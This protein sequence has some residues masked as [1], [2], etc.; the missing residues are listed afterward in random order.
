MNEKLEEID[1][2]KIEILDNSRIRI[3]EGDLRSLIED[4]KQRGLLQPIGVF[5]VGSKYVLRFG[6]RRLE[7]CKK[8][9]YRTISAKVNEG[10]ISLKR[11]WAD[12]YA[13]NA[14]RKDLT[15][16][17][18][19]RVVQHLLNEGCSKSEISAIITEPIGKIDSALRILKKAPDE[20]N[21]NIKWIPPNKTQKKAGAISASVANKIIS[22]RAKDNEIKELFKVAK[23]RQFRAGDIDIIKTFLQEGYSVN[24]AIKLREEYAVISLGEIIVSKSA[25]KRYNLPAKKLIRKIINKYDKKLLLKRNE[26]E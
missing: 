11:Y 1:I 23:S 7:A 8:L 14:E 5:K 9:G 6:G 18:F 17:E 10:D 20:F 22:L 25:F 13:E 16:S 15:V 4:I 26:N 12:N 21:E 3:E 2:D 24:E 19:A